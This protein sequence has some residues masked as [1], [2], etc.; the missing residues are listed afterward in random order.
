MLGDLQLSGTPS[1]VRCVCVRVCV[2]VRVR[3]CVCVCLCG[4]CVCVRVRV[5]VCV[6]WVSCEKG[7]IDLARRCPHYPDGSPTSM[8]V[9]P[10]FISH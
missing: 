1:N 3:V 10:N 6:C 7:R 4:V 5:R 8:L 2:H 9:S